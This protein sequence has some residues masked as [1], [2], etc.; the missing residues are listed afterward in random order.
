MGRR[1]GILLPCRGLIWPRRTQPVLDLVFHLQRQSEDVNKNTDFHPASN[2]SPCELARCA[3]AGGGPSRFS[4]SN[5]PNSSLLSPIS[6]DER[7]RFFDELA[8]GRGR[9]MPMLVGVDG[10]VI[11]DG[12][13]RGFRL[14]ASRDSLPHINWI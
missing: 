8:I 4:G 10:G 6:V 7:F 2:S 13:T 1:S 5:L 3:G 12:W 11:T 14:L 9:S